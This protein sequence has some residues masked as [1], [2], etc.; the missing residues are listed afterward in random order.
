MNKTVSSSSSSART[1][2]LELVVLTSL[3]AHRGVHGGL[4]L[5]RKFLNGVAEYAA[6]WPGPVTTLVAPA[7]A[8]IFLMDPLEVMPGER[9]GYAVEL[10]PADEAALLERLAR[11]AVVLA[12][13]SPAEGWLAA[14]CK[15]LGVPLVYISEYSLHTE[16][17]IVDAQTEN[18]LLRWRR[19]HWLAGAERVRLAALREAAGVQC[20]GTPTY[21]AYRRVNPR[22][23]L[24]FDNRVREAH[25]IDDAGLAARAA[26]LHAGRPLRL[27]F[28]GRLVAMKGVRQLPLV[29]R[30][31][32]R[33]DVPFTLDIYGGGDQESVLREDIAR[34]GLADR[35]SLHGVLDFDSQWVPLLKARA[36][37]F[38]CCHPQ[39]DPSST[40]PEVLSCGVPIAG[41]D[42]EAFTGIVA[43]SGGGWLAPMNEPRRLASLIAGLHAD[44]AQIVAAAERGATFAR[45]HAFERTFAARTHHLVALS[46]LPAV[47]KDGVLP[48][49]VAA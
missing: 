33:L 8:P 20:S 16:R 5:T 1:E 6:H 27:V 47:L 18:P 2:A 38:L 37:V 49:A 34:L 15:R 31:L 12:F 3:R 17:Q 46:R 23:L 39:G 26:A 41:Y 4:V 9:R 44:R 11:A 19:K 22:A 36:D 40:Y 32:V 45:R 13:L 30:E 35:M 29:A 25:V 7:P 24:F 21:E 48:S 10:R 14:A 28:G 42:N 43:H